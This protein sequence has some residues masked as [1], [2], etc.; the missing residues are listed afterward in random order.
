[1]KLVPSSIIEQLYALAVSPYRSVHRCARKSSETRRRTTAV[2]GPQPRR[3]RSIS[4][5]PPQPSGPGPMFPISL[6]LLA[7]RRPVSVARRSW[8]SKKIGSR[9]CALL[10]VDTTW[11][12]TR[13]AQGLA[14]SPPTRWPAHLPS[15]FLAPLFPASRVA[16]DRRASA[17]PFSRRALHIAARAQRCQRIG[18]QAF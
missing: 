4:R 6:S 2:A 1:M 15:H 5:F 11:R 13:C 3:Q 17:A 18:R 9:R 7:R 12:L 16:A 8:N 14:G 10:Y